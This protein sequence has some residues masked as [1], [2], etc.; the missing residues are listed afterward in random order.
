MT[1]MIKG[2]KKLS[3]YFGPF[4]L[5]EIIILIINIIYEEKEKKKQKKKKLKKQYI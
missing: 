3:H 5:H 2:S 1:I 4:S